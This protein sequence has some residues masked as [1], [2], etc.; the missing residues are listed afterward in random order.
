VQRARSCEDFGKKSPPVRRYSRQASPNAHT[1]CGPR[2]IIK[3]RQYTRCSSFV[4]ACIGLETLSAPNRTIIS[5][6]LHGDRNASIS[7]R[8]ASSLARS[9]SST[10]GLGGNISVLFRRSRRETSENM[11]RSRE[12]ALSAITL[13]AVAAMGRLAVDFACGS[14]VIRSL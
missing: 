7:S 4:I 14:W 11:E 10:S 6:G 13:L 12:A 9:R 1:G 5:S 3:S 2:S 8:S